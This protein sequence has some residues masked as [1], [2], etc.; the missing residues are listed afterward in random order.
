MKYL[1]R[2][3]HARNTPVVAHPKHKTS[4]NNLHQ[5]SN[6]LVCLILHTQYSFPVMLDGTKKEIDKIELFAFGFLDLVKVTGY[7]V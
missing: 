2:Q 5:Q 6:R 3:F 7:L 1:W 4:R